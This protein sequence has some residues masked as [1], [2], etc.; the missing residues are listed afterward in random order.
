MLTIS[1]IGKLGVSPVTSY[2]MLTLKIQ[3]YL[4]EFLLLVFVYLGVCVLLFF[5]LLVLL[6]KKSCYFTLCCLELLDSSLLSSWNY[7]CTGTSS[8]ALQH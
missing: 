5:C 2:N 8:S 6:R 4:P 7:R 3:A 1:Y